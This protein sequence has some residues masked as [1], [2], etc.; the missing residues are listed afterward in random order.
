MLHLI[1][2]STFGAG[3]QFEKIELPDELE[4]V[5]MANLYFNMHM[6]EKFSIGFIMDSQ[7]NP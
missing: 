4:E 2:Q 1:F 5:E 3:K 6:N 7:E